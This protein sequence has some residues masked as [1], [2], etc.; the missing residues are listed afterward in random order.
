[1]AGTAY[2]ELD[3]HLSRPILQSGQQLAS[4]RAVA[5]SDGWAG[6]EGADN[7]LTPYGN[8]L[9]SPFRDA[10]KIGSVA[11]R[12]TSNFTIP[13]WITRAIAHLLYLNSVMGPK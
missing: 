9:A 2:W 13:N 10:C 8:D 1:M 3:K 11:S 7:C 4:E 12:S 6:H 5:E